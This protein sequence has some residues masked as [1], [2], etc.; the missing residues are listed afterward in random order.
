M[1]LAQGVSSDAVKPWAEAVV[2][3]EGSTEVDSVSTLT[4]SHGGWQA[5][6]PWW[7]GGRFADKH[8]A[9]GFLQNPRER[10]RSNRQRESKRLT[11]KAKSLNNLTSE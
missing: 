6:I 9:A 2:S 8:K 1:P 4:H 7:S 3:S 5:S 10:K 11:L